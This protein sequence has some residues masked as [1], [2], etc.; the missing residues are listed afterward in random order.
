MTFFKSSLLAAVSAL[1]L[2]GAAH[3]DPYQWQTPSYQNQGNENQML[4]LNR[5]SNLIEVQRV[6][7]R[8]TGRG[9]T[10]VIQRGRNNSAGIAQSGRNNN[11]RVFQRGNNTNVVVNQ[12][13]NNNNSN[14]VVFGIR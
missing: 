8:R 2:A 3:A 4:D 13:G 5:L 14:V 10:S 9:Y 7:D 1:G 11:A 12:N 6:Y